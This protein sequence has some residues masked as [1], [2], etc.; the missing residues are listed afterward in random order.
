MMHTISFK[1][2][3]EQNEMITQI[4][5]DAGLSPGQLAR[6]SALQSANLFILESAIRTAKAEIIEAGRDDLRKAA[7][8]IVKNLRK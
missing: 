6:F 7:E 1:V 4:A 5:R 8:Y 2:N 3:D